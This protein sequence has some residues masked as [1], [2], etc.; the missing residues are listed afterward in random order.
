MS[1]FL[2]ALLT[3]DSAIHD[4]EERTQCV[5]LNQMNADGEV[6]AISDKL[7]PETCGPRFDGS[8]AM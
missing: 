2:Q 3:S 8:N 1:Q 6:L 5:V 4:L 7:S